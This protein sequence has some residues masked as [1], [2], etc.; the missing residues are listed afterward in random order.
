MQ[1]SFTIPGRIRGKGRPRVTMRDG[2]RFPHVYT[3]QE[4][5]ACET[6]VRNS[7]HEAMGEWPPFEGP[8]KLSIAIFQLIPPSWSKKKTAAAIY[9]TGKPDVDNVVK[10]IGDGMNGIVW[11]DDSQ[12]SDLHVTRRYLQSGQE[13]VEITIEELV[14]VKPDA[15]S[16]FETAPLFGQELRA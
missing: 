7:A 8:V 1:V 12:I 4:T 14:G 9:L 2:S 15:S 16:T 11:R 5:V 13:R 10:L 3:D 6:L